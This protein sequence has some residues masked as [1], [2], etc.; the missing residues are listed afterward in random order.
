MK[1]TALCVLATLSLV[2]CH[3]SS[4]NSSSGDAATKPQLTAFHAASDM[5][6]ATFLRVEE[7][8]SSIGYG[9]A[10]AYRAVDPDTYSLHFDSRL[11]G[12]E[13][14]TCSGDINKNGTKDTNECTRLVTKSVNMIN[15]HEYIAAL[16]GKYG[17]LDMT[18][19]DDATHV[20]STT[21]NNG[22]GDTD[23]QVQF[24]NWSSQL[25][26][27]DVYL[28]PPGTNLSVTQ[29]KATLSAGQE[30]NGLVQQGTYVL[31]LT[32]VGDPNNPFYLSQTFA[33]APRTHVGFG[34]LDGTADS[35]STI[36][37]SRFRDQGG[38]LLDR[39][40][41]TFVRAAHVAP[42]T[43]N[44]DIYA[45]Q[46][47]TAPMF[48]NLGLKQTTDYAL[49]DPS[50]Q[51]PLELDITQANNVGVFL[52]R[53]QLFITS[54][55]RSTVFLVNTANGGLNGLL[56]ID[57]A[58]RIAPYAQLRLVNS[59]PQS[60]D[61]YVIPHDNNVFT[62]TPSQV[63]ASG[64]LGG[65]Q[66]FDPGDYDLWILRTGTTAVAFGPQLLHMAGGGLYTIVGV[67]TADIT[68]AEILQL[69]DF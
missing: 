23:A 8:W 55:T 6:D 36:K 60:L 28:E 58:H 13:T 42:N 22:T 25:G 18:I 62:S 48:A 37:V 30:F 43:G 50:S 57:S 41:Q 35:T 29:V 7:V 39:R 3:H 69:G 19:Y 49:V 5:P 20:F 53:Q 51:N 59:V 56:A 1:K 65:S 64:T 46:N 67:P 11:P 38:D 15:G 26:S 66:L 52:S 54:S 24:F 45:Q 4:N 61:Y 21:S 9:V 17:A 32:P 68:R 16:V 33:L 14:T 47:Y 40:V 34:V 12:D 2:G 63:L 27:F 44:V 31:T 10:E